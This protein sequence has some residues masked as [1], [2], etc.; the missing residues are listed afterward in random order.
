MRLDEYA[1]VG[2][3]EGWMRKIFINCALEKIRK[4]KIFSNAVEGEI[5]IEDTI[6]SVLE[7]LTEMEMLRMIRSL[8]EGYRTVFNLSLIHILKFVYDIRNPLFRVLG[9]VIETVGSIRE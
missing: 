3:F 9:A 5:D 4:E 7:T 1:A 6:P 8:P 2:S